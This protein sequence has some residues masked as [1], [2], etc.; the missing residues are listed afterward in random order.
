M[1]GPQLDKWQL[2]TPFE[3][4]VVPYL[5]QLSSNKLGDSG[6]QTKKELCVKY[7]I[8]FHN[9]FQSEQMITLY[10]WHRQCCGLHHQVQPGGM[11]R[12]SAVSFLPPSCSE[13]CDQVYDTNST[14]SC[15]TFNHLFAWIPFSISF[16]CCG[17]L[18]CLRGGRGLCYFTLPFVVSRD[19]IQQLL[20]S[21]D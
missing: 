7:Y 20:L 3:V 17:S 12:F 13:R 5:S 10:Y 21:T 14:V 11:W 19:L 8:V 15:I 9:I 6:I 18:F 1:Q 4:Q 2:F 16:L